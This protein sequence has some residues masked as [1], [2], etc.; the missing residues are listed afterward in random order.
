MIRTRQLVALTLS[1]ALLPLAVAR[2]AEAADPPAP[3]PAAMPDPSAP[4]VPAPPPADLPDAPTAPPAPPPALPPAP[5]GVPDPGLMPPT[6]P[7]A[8]LPPPAPPPPAPPPYVPPPAPVTLPPSPPPPPRIAPTPPPPPPPP[9]APPEVLAPP[10][11][12]AAPPPPVP[13]EPEEKSHIRLR[14]G[15]SLNGGLVHTPDGN[16][17]AFGLAGRLGVQ[18]NAYFGL[19]YQNT[20]LATFAPSQASRSVSFHAGFADY[21]TVLASLTLL[22]MLE[23]A[24]GPSVDYAK[25]ADCSAG[26]TGFVPTSGCQSGSSVALG[27]HGRV[28]FDF[29]GLFGDGNE[30]R[31][32]FMIN[33]DIHPLLLSDVSA[34]SA[35]LGLGAE[36]Y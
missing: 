24:V 16:G 20:P 31:S 8:P 7:P 5:T 22:D 4:P 32:G 21:N 36:W 23:I 9:P 28:S 13:V 14:G 6:P 26:V 10:P 25:Y 35:T 3:P 34:F 33:A 18:I 17:P 30:R 29:G 11:P 1:L 12:V 19:Y 2:R 15:F 27:G